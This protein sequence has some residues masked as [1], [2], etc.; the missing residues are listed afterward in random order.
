MKLWLKEPLEKLKAQGKKAQSKG[1]KM[2]HTFLAGI[3]KPTTAFLK[4]HR[5]FTTITSFT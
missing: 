5:K 3:S 1:T 4:L 2:L